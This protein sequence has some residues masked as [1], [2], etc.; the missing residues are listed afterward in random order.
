MKR[1]ACLEWLRAGWRVIVLAALPALVAA[2]TPR[3]DWSSAAVTYFRDGTNSL[4]EAAPSRMLCAQ[5]IGAE[6]PAADRPSP[7]Q[8]RELE[9]C[10]S[11][12]LFYG[13]G[14]ASNLVA[15][16]RCAILEREEENGQDLPYFSGTG[17]LAVVYANGQG[18]ARKLT[19]A[20]HMACGMDDAVAATQSRVMHLGKLMAASVS[21]PPF[22]ICDDAT[23]GASGGQCAA[24]DAELQDQARA[25]AFASLQRGWAKARLVAFARA[26]ASARAYADAVHELDCYGGTGATDCSIRGAQRDLDRFLA[27]IE[28]LLRHGT[29]PLAPP[30]EDRANGATDPAGWNRQVA[31]LPAAE[32]TTYLSN[33]RDVVVARAVFERDLLAFAA[34]VPGTTPHA[35]RVLFADL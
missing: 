25:R 16:R 7:A 5:V 4:A 6:P 17:I 14:Q 27:K 34:T 19:V 11:E 10:N 1:P 30:R 13:I 28:A 33:G 22:D 3:Y 29:P 2:S 20:T 31:D 35:V 24:H 21:R 15:A 12:A 32:R 26:P 8:A 23:S 9:G 18:A